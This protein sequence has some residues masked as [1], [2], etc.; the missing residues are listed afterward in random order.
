[1]PLQQMATLKN[2]I[3]NIDQKNLFAVTS[4]FMMKKQKKISTTYKLNT[5]TYKNM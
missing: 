1:M 5:Q 3:I 4:Q 2:M